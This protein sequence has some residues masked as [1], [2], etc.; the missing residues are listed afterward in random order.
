MAV[1]PPVGG[2]HFVNGLLRCGRGRL[3]DLFFGEWDGGGR[4]ALGHSLLVDAGDGLFEKGGAGN[5]GRY[6]VGVATR[7]GMG[8]SS[9]RG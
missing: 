2:H 6:P 8:K 4:M 7:T 5:S 1:T 9:G 3:C